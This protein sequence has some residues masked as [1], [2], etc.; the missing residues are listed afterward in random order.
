M[1]DDIFD[2]KDSSEVMTWI[3]DCDFE[4]LNTPDI[5]NIVVAGV[6]REDYKLRLLMAGVPEERIKCVKSEFDA[7]TELKYQ[8]TDKI[9]ILHELYAVDEA[10]QLRD[11]ICDDLKKRGVAHE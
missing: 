10:L 5:V 9:Y 2:R 4:F 6:R 7:P 1:V 3:Y 8:G 11:Q